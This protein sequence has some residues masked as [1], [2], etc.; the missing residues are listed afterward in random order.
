MGGSYNRQRPHSALGYMTPA[1]FAG[2]FTATGGRLRNP[3]PL[4]RPPVAPLASLRQSQPKTLAS[5]G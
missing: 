3:D 1:A 2:T 5:T 4:R